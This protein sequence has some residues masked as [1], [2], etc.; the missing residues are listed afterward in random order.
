MTISQ[1][2]LAIASRH[3]QKTHTPPEK[4]LSIARAFLFS[5]ATIEE[6]EGTESA[7]LPMI[8]NRHN[9]HRMGL[10]SAFGICDT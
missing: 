3:A 6:I 9:L 5:E 1:T 2:L 8:P 10:D 7:A 4:A